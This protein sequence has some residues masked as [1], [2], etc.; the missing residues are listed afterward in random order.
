MGFRK[1][2]LTEKHEIVS[3]KGHEVIEDEL[4]KTGKHSVAEMTDK[5]RKST[6]ERIAKSDLEESDY[7][8][9]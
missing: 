9:L 7:G 1:Y 3:L 6:L 5:E 2:Q 4:R 8:V